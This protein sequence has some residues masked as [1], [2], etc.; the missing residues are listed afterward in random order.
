M[1]D[2]IKT[3]LAYAMRQLR[4]F[5]DCGRALDA[6]E[7]IEENLKHLECEA[8]GEVLAEFNPDPAE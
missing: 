7:R 6:L 5:Q 3:D 8:C 2:S 4:E 1:Y